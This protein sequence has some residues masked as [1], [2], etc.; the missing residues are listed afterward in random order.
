MIG[1]TKPHHLG[2]VAAL[3]VELDADQTRKPEEPY[4]LGMPTAF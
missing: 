4:T 3:S 2:A 1:P